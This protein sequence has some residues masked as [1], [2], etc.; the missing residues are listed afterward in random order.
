MVCLTECGRTSVDSEVEIFTDRG[1][2]LNGSLRN[3][4]W[5]FLDGMALC[6]VH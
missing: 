3:L 5:D 1:R 2:D 4:T 6:G